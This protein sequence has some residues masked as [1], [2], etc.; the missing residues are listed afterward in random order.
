MGI[1]TGTWC[2]LLPHSTLQWCN[3]VHGIC[4]SATCMSA[5]TRACRRKSGRNGR[6]EGKKE[7]KNE[8]R[9]KEGREKKWVWQNENQE[10]GEWER[11]WGDESQRKSVREWIS[12]SERISQTHDGRGRE[13]KRNREGERNQYLRALPK[14]TGFRID[15]KSVTR[16]Q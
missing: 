8:G 12:E 15:R 14:Y 9:K 2:M 1:A 5:C 10:V 16:P 13:R 3:G 7:G 6:K 4:M 11:V